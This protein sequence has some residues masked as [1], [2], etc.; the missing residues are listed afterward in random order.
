MMVLWVS[1][2]V[3]QTFSLIM[4]QELECCMLRSR[5]RVRHLPDLARVNTGDASHDHINRAILDG[6]MLFGG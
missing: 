6:L 2:R 3:C 5:D 4:T 1:A